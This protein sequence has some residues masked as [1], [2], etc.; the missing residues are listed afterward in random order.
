MAPILIDNKGL[1]KFIFITVLA[2][3][4]IFAVG[5]FSGYQQASTFYTTGP[6]VKTL[7]LPAATIFLE[8]DIE[9]QLPAVILAGAE[10]DVDWPLL[11]SK[12]GAVNNV[13]EL[14][15]SVSSNKETVTPDHL[16][17]KPSFQGK[18][19]EVVEASVLGNIKY[20]IQVGV[21]QHRLNAENKVKALQSQ[22]LDAYVSGH[23]DK[24]NRY[25]VRF[26]YFFD[27]Q[28]AIT[29]L[30]KYRSKERRDAYLVNFSA[31]NIHGLTISRNVTGVVATEATVKNLPPDVSQVE[32][33]YN[34]ISSAD[35]VST[36]E[37]I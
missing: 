18:L 1:I 24:K 3:V 31:K 14:Q 4:S 29:A 32:T 26:G 28:S 8:S 6:N 15:K 34:N 16:Q 27:K 22:Y 33:G 17:N 35:A 12:S 2:V 23:P 20:S 25:N 9:Q 11:E 7:A 36:R 19:D 37:S 10:I 21:F 13:A 30:E 5:F